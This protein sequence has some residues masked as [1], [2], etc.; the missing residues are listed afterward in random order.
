M[1]HLI[2]AVKGSEGDYDEMF[3]RLDDKFGNSRKIVDLVVSDLKSLKKISD[4]D[5]KGFIKMVDQVEQCWLDLKRVSL[6]DEL[7][8]VNVVSHIER[9][10]P[11]LQKR[12]W[13]IKADEVS[14]TSNLFPELLKFLQKEKKSLGVHEF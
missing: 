1:K 12:E 11:S 10:L 13:V 14:V 5:V 6:S 2:K 3:Q 7:N 9:V 4:G 8:T